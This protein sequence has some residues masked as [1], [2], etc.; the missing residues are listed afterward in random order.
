MRVVLNVHGGQQALADVIE[1]LVQRN[2]RALRTGAAR[3][4]TDADLET[5]DPKAAAWRDA[6]VAQHDDYLSGRSAAAWYAATS[7][8]SGVPAVVGFLRGRPAVFGADG[9]ALRV[10]G[11]PTVDLPETEGRTDERMLIAIDDDR[12]LPVREVNNAIA[13]HNARQIRERGLP[14]LYGG[15]VRYKTEGSP[16]L[17]WD[18][19]EIVNNGFD[20]CEGLS[21]Y[22]AGELLND[23]VDAEVYTRLVQKPDT[24][25]GG[26]GKGR[27]FHAVTRARLPDGRVVVDDPSRRLGMPAPPWYLEWAKAQR[28][29]GRGL[30]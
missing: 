17:W 30:G 15:G 14:R 26:T 16:E 3:R 11:G 19:Q 6:V 5:I 24:G 12:A 23:G 21:A 4:L 25:M 1:G 22:R 13:R 27:L 8:V 9:E 20:D 2:E 10:F 29:A 28:A 18:A 7:R